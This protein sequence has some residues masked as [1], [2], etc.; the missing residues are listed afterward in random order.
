MNYINQAPKE[1]NAQ[2]AA[3]RKLHGNVNALVQVGNPWSAQPK[4]DGVH[5][6]VHTDGEGY[7]RTRTGEEV[8]SVPHI[9]EQAKAQA[10]PGQ[11]LFCEA[12]L[13]GEH[14][15]AINGTVRR[16]SPQPN[17]LAIVYDVVPQTCFDEGYDPTPYRERFRK[18]QTFYGPNI[19]PVPSMRIL[20]DGMTAQ[21]YALALTKMPDAYDG[22]ILRDVT[23]PWRR[24]ASKNGEV[25][26]VKP[27]LTLDLQVVGSYAEHRDTKL[28]GYLT[29]S[30]NGM[31]SDVGSGLTQAMLR[32]IMEHEDRYVGQV[33][34][35]E[36]LGVNPS[37]KLRE[38]RL[39]GFRFDTKPEELK[40]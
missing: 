23:A 25:I 35:V 11:V 3:F 33:A 32:E 9:I 30:Y 37:G 26:K 7:A 12:Y 29:V 18:L 22:A 6:M 13:F 36:C 16:K 14:H 4:Y 21:E 1:F 2:S 27:S 24:G 38:P 15:K 20:P 34:E 19:I 8:L 28:G 17:L 40:E 31:L 10:G 39:K 5:I